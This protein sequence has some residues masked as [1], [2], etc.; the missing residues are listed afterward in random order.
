M[1]KRNKSLRV[2]SKRCVCIS[3]AC[4]GAPF[5]VSDGSTMYFSDRASVAN[6][7]GHT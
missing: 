4:Y 1:L 5:Y 7:V 2:M 6:S 3:Y